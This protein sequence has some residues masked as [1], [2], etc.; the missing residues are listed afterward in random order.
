[1]RSLALN[2]V[3]AVIWLF[4]QSEPTLRDFAAGSALGFALLYLF[5]PVLKSDDYVRRVLAASLFGLVF[6]REFLVS[7]GELFYYTLFVPTSRLRPE[8]IIYDVSGMTRLEILLLSHCISLTPGTNTVDISQ[9]FTRLYLHALDCPDPETVRR[10][11][12]TTLKQ[13]ILAFTR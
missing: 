4:L 2:L 3:M 10:K 9:D 5:R 8:F 13:A 7:C 6:I 12:D 1:M 11:I